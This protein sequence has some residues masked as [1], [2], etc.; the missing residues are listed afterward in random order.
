[1][2]TGQ[3]SIKQKVQDKI[4]TEGAAC[5]AAFLRRMDIRHKGIDIEYGAELY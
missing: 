1:M 5:I 2:S 4:G 3:K